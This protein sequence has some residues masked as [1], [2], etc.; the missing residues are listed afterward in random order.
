MRS[1]PPKN[2]PASRVFINNKSWW[3]P[4]QKN[5]QLF[6]LKQSPAA[7][8]LFSQKK[9]TMDLLLPRSFVCYGKTGEQRRCP[10]NC[11]FVW[12]ETKAN[13][14]LSLTFF[15]FDLEEKLR[16]VARLLVFCLVFF[17]STEQTF[18]KIKRFSFVWDQ[19]CRLESWKTNDTETIGCC[20][21][22]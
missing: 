10:S 18:T 9:S 12:Q 4:A 6:C 7:V 14:G 15:C 17:L 16:N 1:D 5:A 11:L 21:R 19:L 2:E 20:Q 3:S 13:K 22:A 8:C